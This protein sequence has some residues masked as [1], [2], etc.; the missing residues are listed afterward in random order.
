MVPDLE[1]KPFCSATWNGLSAQSLFDVFCLH[2]MQCFAFH[3]MKDY[4]VT[5]FVDD[6]KTADET[7]FGGVGVAEYV[8]SD[9]FND[10]LSAT[11]LY[12]S[13]ICND[14]LFQVIPLF[15]GVNGFVNSQRAQGLT[16][17][18]TFRSFVIPKGGA[19][20]LYDESMPFQSDIGSV[21]A[22]LRG[23]GVKHIGCQS[24][25]ASVEQV[26]V[27][28]FSNLVAKSI[29]YIWSGIKSENVSQDIVVLVDRR[30]CEK[31]Q[32]QMIWVFECPD[33]SPLHQLRTSNLIGF[34]HEVNDK[35]EVKSYLKFGVD[36]R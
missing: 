11:S 4:T 23:K 12:P 18:V 6:A 28:A 29:E 36:Q 21:D 25:T 30:E 10:K 26:G 9:K 33:F 8:Q 17:N 19:I 1:T 34:D 20:S 32:Y 22:F 35:N 3:Q 14:D 27:D 5:Q 16:E 13:W 7:L 15:F 2:K 24:M 31:T